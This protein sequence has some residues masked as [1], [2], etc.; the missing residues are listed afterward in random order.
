MFYYHTSKLSGKHKLSDIALNQII[1]CFYKTP[2]CWSSHIRMCHMHGIFEG[3]IFG[4]GIL[5]EKGF[6]DVLSFQVM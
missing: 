5:I 1:G 3:L 6:C 2:F 4:D